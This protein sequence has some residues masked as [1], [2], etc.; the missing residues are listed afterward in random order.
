MSQ[1][2]RLRDV[3]AIYRLIGECRDLGGDWC[4]WQQRMQEGLCRLVGAQVAIGG[5]LRGFRTE[6]AEV[7]GIVDQGWSGIQEREYWLHYMG[8]GGPNVDPVL[9]RAAQLPRRRLLTCTR[10]ELID[11]RD[12]YGSS[13]FNELRRQS[14]LDACLNSFAS[15]S[16]PGDDVS[17]VITL[18]RP[19]GDR[20]F[21]SRERLMVHWF[22]HELVPLVGRQ[23]AS[24]REPSLMALS[25]RQRQTLKC[26]LAGASEKQIA[27]RLGIRQPTVHE[28]VTAIYRHFGVHSRA[29]LL[30]RWLHFDRRR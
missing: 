14:R 8:Q 28:Y 5:E 9:A 1:V 27:E 7:V 23:L 25:P 24:A 26:L 22:Q 3:R 2:L 11:D 30:A 6:R 16:A 15:L 19:L 20:P 29:E 21:G 13:H 12:W 10:R 4:G 17:H 18:H